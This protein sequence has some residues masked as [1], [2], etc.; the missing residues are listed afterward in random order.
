MST[1][2]LTN[3]DCEDARRIL[4]QCESLRIFQDGTIHY[5]ASFNLDKIESAL[6]SFDDTKEAQIEKCVNHDEKGQPISVISEPIEHPHAEEGDRVYRRQKQ[7]GFGRVTKL[8]VKDEEGEMREYLRPTDDLQEK[9]ERA[10]GEEK[11]QYTAR[12]KKVNRINATRQGVLEWDFKSDELEEQFEDEM[13]SIRQEEHEIEV[14]KRKMSL[15]HREPQA[16]MVP[17]RPI[18]WMFYEDEE[19]D[20]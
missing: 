20:A 18:L 6:K 4:Q 5:A 12:L 14:R 15:L 8:Y 1:V 10:T 13:E 11:Q 19:D 7:Q 9:Q 2:K 17:M 3:D 16:N